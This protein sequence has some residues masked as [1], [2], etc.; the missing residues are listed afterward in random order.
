MLWCWNIK[1]LVLYRWQIT[2]KITLQIYFQ[3]EICISQLVQAT[4]GS[5]SP[6]SGVG[7]RCFQSHNETTNIIRKFS[8]YWSMVIYCWFSPR[9]SWEKTRMT[10]QMTIS[11]VSANRRHL[12]I[13]IEKL[14][15]K[16]SVIQSIKYLMWLSKMTLMWLE[17]E[18]PFQKCFSFFRSHEGRLFRVG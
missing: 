7:L 9:L 6:R 16:F 18:T 13:K 4:L 12:Q 11:C 5:R 8:W 1:I 2:T 17:P 14:V 10:S 3:M 15:S